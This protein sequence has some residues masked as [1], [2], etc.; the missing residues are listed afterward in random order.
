ML[1][2]VSICCMLLP[3]IAQAQ[4]KLTIT[5]SG[6]P[7]TH[8]G[9]AVYIT[10]NFN[11]WQPAEQS[12]KLQKNADGTL[13]LTLLLKEIPSDR[14]EYKFTRGDWQTLECTADGRLAEPRTALLHRDTVIDCRIEGWRDDFPASTA[15]ANVHLLDSVFHIPQLDVNRTV[16]IYLPAD[17]HTSGKRYPVMY[18]HDGQHLFDEATSQGRTGPVE[19]GVDEVMDTA[20]LKMIV[21]AVNHN[22]EMKER[23]KEYYFR[24]NEDCP[25]PRGSAYLDFIV[26]TL[27]PYVDGRF[28]TLSGK[29]HTIM[30]GS[31]MG[32]LITFYAGLNYPEVFGTL[33]VFSPSVWL[34]YGNIEKELTNL[35][36]TQQIN[37]QRYYFY[38]GENENRLKPDQT[39]VHMKDDVTRVM[40]LLTQKASPSM[41]VS[42]NPQGRHGA[43][44]WRMAFPAFYTWLSKNLLL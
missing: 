24:A 5:I 28:R 37:S 18:M 39:F 38:A 43:L 10:G 25:Q 13:G 35:T 44:Y 1:R 21:V 11:R 17:Y 36:N 27:K 6:R 30:A 31:S 16:W 40:G 9:D 42:V 23:A 2:K 20:A 34:D 22:P 32:G 33:G 14:L 7:D 8:T 19:W 15:S 26:H 29:Q 4:Q 12:M 41:E 3:F